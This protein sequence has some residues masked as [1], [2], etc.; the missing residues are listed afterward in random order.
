MTKYDIASWVEQENNPRNRSFREAVHTILIAIANNKNLHAD[1]IMKGGILLALRYE[2]QRYTTDLDFSTSKTI[3]QFNK[4]RFFMEFEKSLLS[5]SEQLDYGLDCRLQ[6][7]RINPPST[8]ASFPTMKLRIGYAYKNNIRDH[9]RLL[10]N[11]STNVVEI[12]LSFNEFNQEIEMMNLTEGGDISI[13]SLTDLV[14]EKFRAILQQEVRNRYRRQDI[15]DLYYL[16]TKIPVNDNK[17]QQILNSLLK[18]SSTR[19]LKIEKKSMRKSEIVKRT[20]KEYDL[21]KLEI[22]G[23]LPDFDKVY[24]LARNFYESL[25]W[26]DN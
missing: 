15:Y 4:N 11:R 17:K 26:S 24:S 1:M 7:H 8:E 12:D 19:D 6:S 5:A 9:R 10:K 20:Q 22:I 21:L 16:L 18:K 3:K 14:A 2:S 25:P 13:Y 23:D